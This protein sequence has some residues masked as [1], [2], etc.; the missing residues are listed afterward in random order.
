M[1]GATGA[2]VDLTRPEQDASPGP[3]SV[4]HGVGVYERPRSAWLRQHL[5]LLIGLLLSL[6]GLGI[7][8]IRQWA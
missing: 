3:V 7:F 5:A 2:M 8:A 4:P 6:V 1:R